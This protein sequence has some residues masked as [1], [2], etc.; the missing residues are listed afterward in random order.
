ML[1]NPVEAWKHSRLIRA[2]SDI[3]ADTP[4]PPHQW[5][6]ATLVRQFKSS[7]GMSVQARVN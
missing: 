1:S 4:S 3:E 7:R 6:R 2:P 5:A